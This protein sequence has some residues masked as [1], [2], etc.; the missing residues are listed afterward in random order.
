MSTFPVVVT[1][2]PIDDNTA[3]PAPTVQVP[4]CAISGLAKTHG[5]DAAYTASDP[6]VNTPN[7]TQ[8]RS[9]SMTGDFRS[10]QQIHANR[11]AAVT[12][13]SVVGQT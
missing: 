13:A 7:R 8:R 12:A 11:Y 4:I 10:L 9:T 2:A 1:L 5:T 6:A 3:P